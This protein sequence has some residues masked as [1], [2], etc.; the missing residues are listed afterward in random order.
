MNQS[1]FAFKIVLYYTILFALIL[2]NSCRNEYSTQ[3]SPDILNIEKALLK[4]EKLSTFSEGIAYITLQNK[5]PINS[6]R[7]ILIS[8]KYIVVVELRKIFLFD[9]SGNYIREIGRRGRGPGEFQYIVDVASDFNTN[10][11]YILTSNKQILKYSIDGSYSGTL[12]FDEQIDFDKIS[13]LD[14]DLIVLS[15]GNSNGTDIYNWIVTNEKGVI[16][17]SKKN[18]HQFNYPQKTANLYSHLMC[19][20]NN[21]CLYLSQFNDTIFSIKPNEFYPKYIIPQNGIEIDEY[22]NQAK[23]ARQRKNL[24][25]QVLMPINLIET[26]NYLFYQFYL[27]REMHL[28][29]YNKELNKTYKITENNNTAF[30]ND[31]DGGYSFLPKYFVEI[32]NNEYVLNWIETYK[33]KEYIKSEEFKTSTPKYPEKKK[34]LE[35]LA[36]SLDENGNPVLMLVK[37]KE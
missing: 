15:S 13:S 28:V 18:H 33:L 1:T 30:E 10:R 8:Q 16:V 25:R 31:V 2:M 17:N 3:D 37:L 22:L 23:L 9:I 21:Q 5:I 36:N 32:E 11:I 35:K 7:K 12:S 19:N 14:E 24:G 20:Y 34:A 6:I 26:K 4:N 27:E 29:Y